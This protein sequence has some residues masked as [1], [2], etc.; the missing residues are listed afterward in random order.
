MLAPFRTFSRRVSLARKGIVLLTLL[1]A[2]CPCHVWALGQAAYVENIN[3]SGDFPLTQGNDTA[4]LMVD[5]GD[6]PGVIRAVG[7]LQAD[8]NR[9]TS[10][11]APIIK[12]ISGLPK[13][14][15]IIGTV[16]K[17]PIIDQLIRDKKID[18]SAITGKWESFFLQ[19]V[20]NPLPGVDS[21]LVIAGSDK[22]GTIY[23]I[24]DLSEQIGVSPWYF[25]ADVPV[26]HQDALYLKPGKYQ[27][28]EPSVK[29]R[30]IFLN[31]EAPDLSGWVTATYGSVPGLNGVANYNHEFYA[32]VFELI[33]RLKGNF[34]WPAMWNNAFN[35]DDPENPRLADEYGIVM[36]TSHQE[37]ML[38]AQKEWDRGPG[39][40]SGN[41][42]FNNV[43]QQPILEQFW[44]DGI[45]HNKNYESILTLGLRAENDSG[46]ATGA[47][48][49]AQIIGLQRQMIAEVYGSAAAK[50]PQLWC[51][52]KEVLDYYNAGLRPPEDVTLLWPDDNWGNIRRLPTAEERTRSG[53]AGIYYHFDYHGGPRSYQWLNTNPLPKIQEQMSLAKQYGADRIWI[54]NV[55]H[56]KGY[57]LP[58]EYFLSLA[59]DANRWTS[60]NTEEFTRLW[61]A[62]EFGP[63]FATDIA[64]IVEKYAKFNARRKPELLDPASYSVSDY[65]EAGQVTADF[66]ALAA[67]AQK[68]YESLPKERQDAFYELV[69]FPTKASANLNDMYFAAAKNALYAAQGRASANDMDAQTR[70]FFAQDGDLMK[71]F[72]Q[73]FAGG[74]WNHFMDEGHIGY[75]PGGNS[76]ADPKQNSLNY[77]GLRQIDVPLAPA[78]GIAI[79]S[80]TSAWPGAAGDAALPQFDVYNQ[81]KSYVDVFNQGQTAFDFTVTADAP[82]IVLSESK[83]TVT[84]DERVWVSID[85]SKA[86]QGT[87]NGTIKFSGA[88]GEATVKVVAFHPATPT[89]ENLQGFVEG[90]GVV[91]IEAA[92]YTKKIDDDDAR[93][94]PLP[95]YG[96][97]LSAMK[98]TAPINAPSVAPGPG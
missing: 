54:V 63:Q 41:W 86:P 1:T 12:D 39:R 2:F 60:D 61:A 52:Y 69:L 55:G 68:L 14:T 29:Y 26:Q 79:D 87:A 95:D 47:D 18:A 66:D 89:R 19:V 64:D 65:N 71:F 70:A 25:W 37:P 35:E 15:V 49:T 44:R 90:Q 21:A 43:A 85:W 6:W 76:W 36:G 94:I 62:R 73:T 88:G 10:R 59:W 48:Q 7:D 13:Y 16:G 28:G 5:A 51:P 84:Q 4:T 11:T 67:R 82:W 81:Q 91:S 83:G 98:T 97:T 34:L 9:V 53:G 92:H 50:V 45:E 40:Q 3:H 27:Q 56:F 30:G 20:P 78:M 42:N 8:I 93:W 75:A 58:M 24:Y 72:N 96:R 77:M 57:E 46:A 31:D 22:R 32:K 23:G 74:K 17:S 38:R 33:L 80:S